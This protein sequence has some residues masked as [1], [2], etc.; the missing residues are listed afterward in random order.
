M[1]AF[2]NP[3]EVSTGVVMDN[4]MSIQAAAEYSGYNLQYIRRLLRTD[5]ISGLKIGQMWLVEI[6][7]KG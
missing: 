7:R 3:K 2:S 5:T 1:I 4:Y 6:A